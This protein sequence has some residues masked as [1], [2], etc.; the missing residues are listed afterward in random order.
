M[1][2]SFGCFVRAALKF[3]IPF[4]VSRPD[5]GCCTIDTTESEHVYFEESKYYCGKHWKRTDFRVEKQSGEIPGRCHRAIIS[6]SGVIAEIR[7]AKDF[8]HAFA[9]IQ[10]GRDNFSWKVANHWLSQRYYACPTHAI[11]FNYFESH[12]SF[13]WSMGVFYASKITPQIDSLS[14]DYNCAAH[15]A[16]IALTYHS[17]RVP[18]NGAWAATSS[19]EIQLQFSL[20]HRLEWEL[21]EGGAT[22][23]IVQYSNKNIDLTF[24]HTRSAATSIY[25]I[26]RLFDSVLR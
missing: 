16:H 13:W 12:Y 6:L 9:C 8:S 2:N 22:S 11:K 21:V 18:A 15:K 24:Q 4:S 1:E 19:D 25:R 23:S 10:S 17:L 7:V 20:S 26:A 14:T 5:D 3:C